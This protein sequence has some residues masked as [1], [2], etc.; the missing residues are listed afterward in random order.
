MDIVSIGSTAYFIWEIASFF[1]AIFGLFSLVTLTITRLGKA[2]WRFGLALSWKKIVVIASDE[3][4]HDL[5]EDLSDSG[6][7]KKK[8]I[9]RVSAKQLAKAK[10]ALLLIIVYEYLSK[11]EFEEVVKEKNVRCGL[12]VY[13]PP[14]KGP[15]S[16]EEM[17]LLNK[18]TF[19]VLCNFRGRLIND[20]LLMM[21]STSFKKSDIK[22][23][24]SGTLR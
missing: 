9:M 3:D 7:I 8:N 23:P 13:C 14:G 1:F 24:L 19:T 10:E 21:L 5:E 12:I 18:T 2:V 4:Y 22:W 17:A 20:V 16:S 11:D 15:I 6:L